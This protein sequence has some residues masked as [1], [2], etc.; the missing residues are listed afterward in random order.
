MTRITSKWPNNPK[1]QACQTV[2]LWHRI[3]ADHSTTNS[4][5][6]WWLYMH[7]IAE[8]IVIGN[9]PNTVSGSTVSNTELSEFFGAHWVP[10][11]ELSEFL[12]AYYLC[13]K[14]NSPSFSQNSPS[15]PQNS[16]RLSE[17]SRPKQYS[18]NSIPLPFP[19]TAPQGFRRVSEGVFEGVSEG[20]STGFRRVLEG[21][22]KGF[23]RVLS[24]PWYG[25]FS[26]QYSRNSIPL[27]FPKQRCWES[28]LPVS[29]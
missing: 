1:Q 18:R 2:D 5:K 9:G 10:G 24:W 29:L 4:Q 16:V 6:R 7:D 12:L 14:A 15:L 28:H 19:A 27:P 26:K 23:R 17:F 22:Q 20:F 3:L 21:F 13:A 25:G 8:K 11:S